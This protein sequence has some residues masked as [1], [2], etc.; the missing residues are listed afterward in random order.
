MGAIDMYLKG[1]SRRYP[2]TQA[3][4]EQIEEIRDTLH[5]K[6]EELQA[7]GKTYEQAAKEAIDSIGDISPLIGEV[8]GNV[9]TVYVNRL[10]RNNAIICSSLIFAE[11]AISWIAA[12]ISTM[13]V[14]K[15]MLLMP[16]VLSLAG[17][18]LGMG[19]WVAISVIT[20][21]R[22]PQKTE[23]VDYPFRRLMRMAL[24]GW[25][26]LSLVLLGANLWMGL[27]IKPNTMWFQWPMIGIA[28]WP[29]NI[30]VYNKQLKS[31]R[32]DA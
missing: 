11:L 13:E 15:P 1:V 20:W 4:R 14:M 22:E 24:V 30:W 18:I 10:S 7:Q 21:K 9:R 16:F 19:V 29:L 32:Y 12:F 27:Y 26:C 25:L 2:D 3:V 5:L 31:G 8:A 28:N 6:T 23:V 17:L